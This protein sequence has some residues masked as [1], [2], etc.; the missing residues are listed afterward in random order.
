[1]IRDTGYS[2][3][4]RYKIHSCDTDF[5]WREYWSYLAVQSHVF[6]WPSDYEDFLDSFVVVAMLR[7]TAGVFAPRLASSINFIVKF[8]GF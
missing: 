1:M 6:F 3:D 5:I 4:T 2:C 7:L 8:Y